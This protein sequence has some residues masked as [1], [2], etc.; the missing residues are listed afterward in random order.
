MIVMVISYCVA[1]ALIPEDYPSKSTN[2]FN[3]GRAACLGAVGCVAGPIGYG[4]GLLFDRRR[5][6]QDKTTLPV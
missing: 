4:L 3:L 1:N 2:G 5:R 6:P